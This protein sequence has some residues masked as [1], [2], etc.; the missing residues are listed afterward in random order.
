[1]KHFIL[2]EHCG[3][4]WDNAL[5]LGN[6]CFGAMLYYNNDVLYM[7]MNHYEVYYNVS[8]RVLPEDKLANRVP[9]KEPGLLHREYV[10]KANGNQPVGNEPY[11]Y[12]RVKKEESLK[13]PGYGVY[14]F[15][16]SYPATGDLEFYFA[17][18]LQGAD[19][20][21]ALCVEDARV[22]VALAR[23]GRE[24]QMETIVARRDCTISR[25]CQSEPGL[26]KAVKLSFPPYR[27][28][29]YPD[30]NY[31]QIDESTFAYTVKFPLSNLQLSSVTFEDASGNKIRN[32]NEF[33]FSGILR[34]CGARGKLAESSY[35][36]DIVLEE[37]EKE[38]HV[39][40]GIFTQWNYK[41]TV[42]EGLA[43]MDQ[44]AADLAGLYLEHKEY[45][46]EFFNRSAI[47]LPDRFLEQI[48]YVNQYALDC[49]SGKDGVMK[50]HACGLNGLWDIKHPNLWGSMWYWDV[51]I[52]AA[53]AGVFS[54]NRLD[55]AKVF[56]DGLQTYA[57]LAEAFA[58]DVHGLEGYAIDYPYHFY[59]ST[60][61][62]CA[63]YLWFLYEYSM[64]Q[65]YLRNQA[66]PLFLKLC[67]FVLGVFK[68]DEERG[69]YS[70]YPDISP[71][72]GALSHDSAI[73]V[74]SVKYLLQFTLKSAEI[75]GDE[76]PMLEKC[77]EVM[78]HLAP[79]HL[80]KD[81]MYGVCIK[82]AEEAPDNLW[83]RHPGVLMPVFPIGE[84]DMTSSQEMQKIFSNTIDF[85]EDR[86]EIGIFQSSW[87]AA[88][89]ARLG[90]GQ[91]AIRL[92]YE[93]GID[94]MLRSNG[95]SAE[96]TDHFIN[97]CLVCRQPLYYPCMMEFTGEM[98][99]A[100]N[101]MLLQSHN[102]LIRVFPALPDG[103]RDYAP[104]HRHGYP[105]QE[106]VDRSN[107]YD[108]W[109]DVSFEKLLAKGAFEVSASLKDGQLEFIQIHSQKGGRARVTS[110]F[111]GDAMKVFC[112]GCEV[113]I[114]LEQ[115][116]YS[117]E[118]E[119]GMIYVIAASADVCTA[120]CESGTG[121]PDACGSREYN[122]M[123]LSRMTY[124][125]RHISLGENPETQY[126]KA[127]D[128]AMRAWYLGNLRFENH[129]VYKFDFTKDQAKDY[130]SCMYAQVYCA[131]EMRAKALTFEA[132]DG[133][134][135]SYKRGYGFETAGKI[136]LVDRGEPDALRRDFVQGT[137]VAEFVIEVPR[138]QYELMV[139]SGDA[140][141]D[142]V[143]ILEGVNGRKA[144]GDVIPAGRYQCK[145]IPIVQEEDEPVR[146]KIS[147]KPGYSWKINYIIMNVIKGY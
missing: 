67:Q 135:F 4:K 82:D 29:D 107:T 114:Q 88:A 12:Y 11:S 56:S 141:Q 90:Q 49:C 115:G 122:P 25:I 58:Q 143:T 26:L 63:Q 124:T 139:I 3:N 74:A 89:A 66:Y 39:I 41:D 128:G 50:H 21:L 64:D 105:I 71:E 84:Y 134:A 99:A 57:Q 125:K 113:P 55:L 8:G 126:W 72:Q 35:G 138:G 119:A 100:V 111:M 44:Y 131:E 31:Q 98:L 144:G 13:N 30:I 59:Y 123:V 20:R 2:F 17:D 62:W 106:Y 15:S 38:F 81:G 108:A 120:P 6:G 61:P 73:T 77:R 147:T 91:K 101:E 65:E 79:Y 92:L 112:D 52:Q 104:S 146:L 54:S 48:Y 75:L 42:Q 10:D 5:P 102:D 9:A 145:L 86:C 33:T 80:T 78:N 46:T 14:K 32:E 40:C 37:A 34:L 23:D 7:P 45:W 94:H 117:F 95:L 68:Y 19:S 121:E 1:M 85:L 133:A 96:E 142:S 28:R 83:I 116:I 18:S 76:N 136:E 87:L 137:E 132:A 70:I 36:A 97:Y 16:G 110:P 103:S 127:V 93:R 43:L 109:R 24:L 69:Y 60:W 129:T 22:D 118:T 130:A 47:C 51:N 140:A 27:D 53:F